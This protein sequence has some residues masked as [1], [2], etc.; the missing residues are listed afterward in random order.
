MRQAAYPSGRVAILHPGDLGS[1]V[2]RALLKNGFDVVACVEGRSWITRRNAEASGFTI[3]PTIDEAV[4]NVDIVLSL[5]PPG[6]AYNVAQ[7]FCDSAVRTGCHPV[8]ID[9]NSISPILARRIDELVSSNKMIFVDGAFVGSAKML[10]DKTILYLSGPHAESV[11]G[12]LRRALNISVLGPETG[13]A[14]G[15]K[16]A[17]YGFNK[18]LIALFLEMVTISERIGK[19]DEMMKCLNR[20]YPGAMEIIG[21]L[22][23]TYP[24][25]IGRRTTE[26]K[27]LVDWL[28][29]MQHSS[30]MARGTKIVF[31]KFRDLSLAADK[32]WTMD[33]VVRECF[34]LKFLNERH[35]KEV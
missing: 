2:G 13:L 16:L 6:S 25:H 8:F 30:S 14:S 9:G 32:A 24:K 17:I 10:H 27:E 26:M 33:E 1:A 11:A 19:S 23:P 3:V 4:A 28:E 18:G 15:F 31:E 5:V 29:S 12:T 7:I 20:F 22:L 34:A 35:D 21:R